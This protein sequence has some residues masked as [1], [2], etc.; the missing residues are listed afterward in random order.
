MFMDLVTRLASAL[1]LFGALDL[2]RI[3]R[4]EFDFEGF[5]NR[6]TFSLVRVASATHFIY[7]FYTHK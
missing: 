7:I 1:A 3:K 5:A 4:D 2:L 6:E